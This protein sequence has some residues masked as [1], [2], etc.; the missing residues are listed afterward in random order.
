VRCILHYFRQ[1]NGRGA[2]EFY[3]S[4]N[5]HCYTRI[6]NCTFPAAILLYPESHVTRAVSDYNAPIKAIL[7]LLFYYYYYYLLKLQMGC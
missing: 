7:L 6:I 4:Y 1:S 3:A 2:G 5:I